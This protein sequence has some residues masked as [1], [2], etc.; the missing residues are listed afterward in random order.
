MMKNDNDQHMQM[1]GEVNFF[2]GGKYI[3]RYNIFC[4]CIIII[5]YSRITWMKYY[6]I[7]KINIYTKSREIALLL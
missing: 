6:N 2:L 3:S 5:M 7:F 4:S 1:H